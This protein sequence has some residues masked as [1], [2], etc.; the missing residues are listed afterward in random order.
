M[1]K[2]IYIF[3]STVRG[4]TEK[5]SDIDVLVI[6]SDKAMQLKIPDT[7]SVYPDATIEKYYETGR[8][9]AWH[10]HL[11]A[12][13]IFSDRTTSFLET[14]GEPNPYSAHKNDFENL[15]DI[16]YE[17]LGEIRAG[18]NSQIFE[19]GIIY[20]A[21]RDIAMIAS[22]K[23]LTRPCFSRYSPYALPISFP[24]SKGIY[25]SAIKARLLSTRGLRADID[26][27][28]ISKKLTSAPIKDWIDKIGAML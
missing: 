19:I 16:L 5:N 20:T 23:L 8:L 24:L 21:L 25:E 26:P 27:V 2:D 14:L 10:L 7:W 28:F 4:E 18:S 6:V 22:T 11:E 3:G 17:S 12:K 9:F 1:N 15:R 13:C